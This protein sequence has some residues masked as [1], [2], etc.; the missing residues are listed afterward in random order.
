VVVQG[1]V[2]KFNVITLTVISYETVVKPLSIP[3]GLFETIAEPPRDCRR[4]AQ[5]VQKD[6]G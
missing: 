5:P 3:D 2:R 6:S 1:S 4:H